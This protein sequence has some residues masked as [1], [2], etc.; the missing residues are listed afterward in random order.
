MIWVV[1]HDDMIS[2]GKRANSGDRAGLV[3]SCG[4]TMRVDITS[5]PIQARRHGCEREGGL[6]FSCISYGKA[7]EAHDLSK[8]K[9][10]EHHRRG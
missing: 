8:M 9:S 5:C 1:R 3:L 7:S 4:F 2:G 6:D 10:Y